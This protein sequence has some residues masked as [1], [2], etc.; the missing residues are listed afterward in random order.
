MIYSF[1]CHSEIFI[2]LSLGAFQSILRHVRST[3][4]GSY[5]CFPI[6]LKDNF[7]NAH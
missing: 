3:C 1:F 5:S 6:V 7:A 4:D 2:L